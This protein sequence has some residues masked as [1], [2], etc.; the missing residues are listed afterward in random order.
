MRV[1]IVDERPERLEALARAL[2]AEGHDVVTAPRERTDLH[3]CIREVAPDVVVIDVQ[4]P[5]RDVLEDTRRIA[6]EQPKPIVMFVD[7][8][9]D[10]S[11]RAAIEAG[12]AA[13]VVNGAS[14]ARVR[15][16]L[17]VA[18][19]RFREHQHLRSELARARSSLAERKLVDRAKGLL[20]ERRGWSED[21]AYRALRQMAMNRNMRLVEVAR[22]V[23][24]MVHLL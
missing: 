15:S 23:L 10:E 20:M 22:S 12:V 5:D 14:P 2:E 16:I 9:D 8:S 1:L 24:E 4:V 17:A 19:A 13:Y 11:T 3:A 21:E 7:E 6:R 18:V